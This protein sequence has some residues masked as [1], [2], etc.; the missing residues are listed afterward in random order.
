MKKHKT[1]VYISHLKDKMT[2]QGTEKMIKCDRL[3]CY[4]LYK[5]LLEWDNV[6]KL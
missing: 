4:K 5:L 3:F 2:T 6:R 1:L